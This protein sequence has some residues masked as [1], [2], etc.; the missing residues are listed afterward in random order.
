MDQ[1]KQENDIPTQTHNENQNKSNQIAQLSR[2]LIHTAGTSA[3]SSYL[4]RE[5]FQQRKQQALQRKLDT[6]WENQ[7]HEIEE[8]VDFKANCLPLARIRKIMKADEKVS[9][10]S[11]ETPVLFAKACEMF[12]TE[13]TM[14]SWAIL[15]ENKRKTLQKSDI[16]SAIS[17]NDMFDFLVDIVPRENTLEHNIFMNIPRRGSAPFANVP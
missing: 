1:K 10:I 15:E 7:N 2:P 12:I 13:L 8:T 14:Q 4:S 3:F 6:F 16:S 9:M 11:S 17:R 5:H